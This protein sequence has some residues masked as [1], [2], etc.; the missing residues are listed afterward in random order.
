MKKAV[1]GA[2][3]MVCGAIGASTQRIVDAIFTANG[4]S[5]SSSGFNLLLLIS[6]LAGLAGAV[7]C[8]CAL[9]EKK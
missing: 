5:L 9:L 2:G 3:L 6:L 7:L 8:V 4:W 1:V